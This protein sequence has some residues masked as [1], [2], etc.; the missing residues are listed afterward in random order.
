M[1]K[2]GYVLSINGEKIGLFDSVEN[3]HLGHLDYARKHPSLGAHRMRVD[4]EYAHDCRSFSDCKTS[5]EILD[6]LFFW[7]CDFRECKQDI[8]PWR[9]CGKIQEAITAMDNIFAGE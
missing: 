2:L 9:L 6:V 3:A 1:K 4:P 7:A 5:T 8:D